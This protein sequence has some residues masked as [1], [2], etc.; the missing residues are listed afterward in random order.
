[1][2][3]SEHVCNFKE[4]L[5]LLVANITIT[6]NQFRQNSASLT[7]I[8]NQS[9]NGSITQSVVKI[10]GSE[11]SLKKMVITTT[12]GE[13]WHVRQVIAQRCS[14][15][16]ALTSMKTT[17]LWMADWLSFSLHEEVALKWCSDPGGSAMTKFAIPW[18][19]R[20]LYATERCD[21]WEAARWRRQNWGFTGFI[22]HSMC[23]MFANNKMLN[24]FLFLL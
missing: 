21:S 8:I 15:F 16:T 19:P 6:K 4:N 1:M 13:P 14:C 10:K 24:F 11:A 2:Q 7:S 3:P 9:I 23:C 5:D 22:Q 18:Q 20:A 17:R 12:M